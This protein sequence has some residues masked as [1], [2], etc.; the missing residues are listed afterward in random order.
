MRSRLLLLI[1][2]FLSNPIRLCGFLGLAESGIH[3]K[4]ELPFLLMFVE[5][6]FVPIGNTLAV[7]VNRIKRDT[8]QAAANPSRVRCTINLRSNGS[9]RSKTVTF[10]Q[11]LLSRR[12]RRLSVNQLASPIRKCGVSCGGTATLMSF[13]PGCASYI[14]TSIPLSVDGA[15]AKVFGLL[16]L[17]KSE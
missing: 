4:T 3:I 16:T 15:N 17:T 5:T 6:K 7:M 1:S 14:L 2:S 9:Q 11:S 12:K 10:K 13:L 8:S